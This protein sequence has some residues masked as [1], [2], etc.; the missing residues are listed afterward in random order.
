ME[1]HEAKP[2]NNGQFKEGNEGGPGRP[3]GSK[4]KYTTLKEAFREAFDKLQ[5]DDKANLATWAKNNPKDFYTLISKLFPIEIAGKDGEPIQ[6]V[7]NV[8]NENIKKL[9]ERT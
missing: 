6:I 4:N 2:I 7:I 3:P 9:V 1:T 8:A 5:E